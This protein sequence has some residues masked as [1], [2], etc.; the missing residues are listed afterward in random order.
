MEPALQKGI[1]ASFHYGLRPSGI[2][3]LGRSENLGLLL[4]SVRRQRPEEEVFPESEGAHAPISLAQSSHG[5]VFP[6][7]AIKEPLPGIDL[8]RKPRSWSG[9]YAHAGLVINSD[10]QIVHFLGDTSPYVRHA[11]GKATFQL[12]RSLREEFVLEVRSALQKARRG[13]SVVRRE[14]IEVRHN[15]QVSEVNI[16]A[17]P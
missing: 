4:R 7:R 11:P 14:A 8:E 17:A 1:L 6:V 16:E 10:L 2:L 5:H 9:R 15:G 3:L 12:M 13:E